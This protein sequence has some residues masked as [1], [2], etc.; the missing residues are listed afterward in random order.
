MATVPELLEALTR[1]ASAN[2][3]DEFDRLERELLAQFE[4][5]FDGMP[6]EVYQRYLEVDRHWPVVPP[7]RRSGGSDR[8]RERVTLE[9]RL[10]VEV[11]AW[12]R[13]VGA[14]CDRSRSAVVAECLD[15]I[16]GDERLAASVR[17]RLH[18]KAD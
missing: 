16:R 7:T 10:P 14:E 11:E 9:V 5:S 13:E 8:R 17:N 2:R 1:A 18:G 4:G 15:L 6:E 3:K 12:L